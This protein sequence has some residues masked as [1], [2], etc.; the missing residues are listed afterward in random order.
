MCN[1]KLRAVTLLSVLFLCSCNSTHYVISLRNGDT[2]TTASRPEFI[3]KTG[4][5]RYRA[6]NGKDALVRSDEVLHMQEQ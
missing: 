1:I 4:Y 2:I 6:I 5:Y 3:E